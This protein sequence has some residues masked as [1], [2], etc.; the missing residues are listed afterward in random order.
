LADITAVDA[1][2][3]IWSD[4]LLNRRADALMLT[5]YIKSAATRVQHEKHNFSSMAIDDGYGEGKTFFLKRLTEHLA[6][7]HPVAYIDAWADDFVDEPLT[8]LAAT[9]ETALSDL[10]PESSETR[11]RWADAKAKAGKIAA[12][13]AKGLLKRG[14]GLLITAAAV[15]AVGT[16]IDGASEELKDALMDD[17]TDAADAARGSF[18]APHSPAK[19]SGMDRRIDDFREGQAAALEFKQSLKALVTAVQA[20]GKELPIVVVIDELD[21]CRPTYAI[22]LLEQVKHLLDVPGIFFVFGLH[23]DQLARAI[24]GV[25]GQAFS[26]SDYLKRFINRTYS[27][28]KPD[29]DRLIGYLLQRAGIDETRLVFP[30]VRQGEKMP[31]NWSVPRLIAEY[32]RGFGLSPRDAHLLIDLLQTCTSLTGEE[33]LE[34]PLLMPM[35]F[36]KMEKLPTLDSAIQRMKLRIAFAYHDQY[37][38]LQSENPQALATQLASRAGWEVSQLQR[39]RSHHANVIY[40]LR[41][42]PGLAQFPLANPQRYRDLVETIGKFSQPSVSPINNRV[43]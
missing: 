31:E 20:S 19:R 24:S 5:D 38:K 23:S 25:Y 30:P 10:F 16:V 2:D 9:I 1:L 13:T 11:D 36:A 33:P 14:A 18:D 34:M 39:D 4:D 6:Q 41:R 35:L 42:R 15:E 40:E 29:L 7:D 12:I 26:G 37:G 8:A 43:G 22:K 21:R 32:M 27:L 3:A 17:V 28:Q